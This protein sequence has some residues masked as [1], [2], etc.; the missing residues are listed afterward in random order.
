MYDWSKKPEKGES[1]EDFNGNVSNT[2]MDWNLLNFLN[3]HFWPKEND[4]NV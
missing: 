3:N 4:F 1:L 2:K